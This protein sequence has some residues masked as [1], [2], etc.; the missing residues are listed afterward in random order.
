[1]WGCGGEEGRGIVGEY[2]LQKGEGGGQVEL[3]Y[4]RF[5]GLKLSVASIYH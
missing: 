1:M 4:R 2:S 5:Q 3:M